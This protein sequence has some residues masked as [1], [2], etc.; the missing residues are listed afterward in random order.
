MSEPENIKDISQSY[1]QKKEQVKVIGVIEESKIIHTKSKPILFV[2]ISSIEDP[3]YRLTGLFFNNPYWAQKRVE[4][5]KGTGKK[6]FFSGNL[7]NFNGKPA[8]IHPDIEE[9]H[10]EYPILPVYKSSNSL[11]E[12]NIGFRTMLN[13]YK[14]IIENVE[15]EES[16]PLGI[17][18]KY[19]LIPLPDAIR[20]LHFPSDMEE[21]IKAKERVKIEEII[22]IQLF[23]K[24][25]TL[26][27]ENFFKNLSDKN[28]ILKTNGPLVKEFLQNLE[29]PLTNDQKRVIQEI[30]N[31]VTSGGQMNRLIQG[32][33]GCGKTIIAIVSLLMAVDSGYQGVFVVPTEILAD[34]HYKTLVKF[35]GEDKVKILVGGI[36]K[37]DKESILSS[38]LDGSA[39]ICVCTHTIFNESTQFQNIG[40]AVI[41]EFCKFG[42]LQ[43]NQILE[44][45]VKHLLIMSAT[46]IPR[47]L[48]LT[49]YGDLNISFIKELPSQRKKILTTILE[50]KDRDNMYKL[51]LDEI[52]KGH[53]V[54]IV[55]PLVE[56]K[57]NS[58]YLRDVESSYQE[59]LQNPMFKDY[60]IGI[61]HGKMDS[62]VKEEEMK[63]FKEKKTQ[64]LMATTVIEVG[65]DVPNATLIVIENSERYGLSQLHQLRGRVGRGSQQ[66][67]CILM[68]GKSPKN[69]D[70]NEIEKEERLSD[71]RLAIISENHCGFEISL[72]D[73][74]L[75]GP[76]DFVGPDQS[77]FISSYFKI[78]DFSTDEVLLE[79]AKSIVDDIIS[80]D[81]SLDCFP[82]IQENYTKLSEN[83]SLGRIF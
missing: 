82:M 44:K 10:E 63:K 71:N 33:V 46:P 59:I 75:R 57:K 36:K 16:F 4:S 12:V 66:S 73:F 72:L 23:F 64:I 61:V 49:I 74:K 22:Y 7:T 51:I 42:V 81:P 38:L 79:I 62:Y 76:G 67:Y 78:F 3:E 40:V 32:D 52:H 6:L 29:F 53:Q 34:Q 13:Y 18:A 37:K 50:E 19:K 55:H 47:S 8:I 68:K 39:K 31:D 17:L 14:E 27:R 2:Y 24:L 1:F 60:Q 43:R 21:L 56:K 5:L 26:R 58:P 30:M 11:K 69:E 45:G 20:I 15:M 77:G 70:E 48:G 83:W 25:L 35:L 65:V 80:Q 41:D 54:Y 28:F 9:Y